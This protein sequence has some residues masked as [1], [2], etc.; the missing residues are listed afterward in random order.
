MNK[1]TLK[2]WITGCLILLSCSLFQNTLRASHIIGGE[3]SYKC[4]GGDNFELTL[5]VYRDCFYG[6]AGF[7]NPA[8]IAIFK[9]GQL[10][11]YKTLNIGPLSIQPIPADVG[12]PCLFVPDDVCVEWGRYRTTVELPDYG[13][14]YHLV[15]QRC[16]RNQTISNIESP[17][18]TGATYT[19]Y[20]TDKARD[21][22][23]SSPEFD[24][25]PPVFICIDRPIEFLHAATDAQGDS[26][27]YRLC[28][29][30]IGATFDTPNPSVP[31]PPPYDSVSWI[32][33][34][35]NISNLLGGDPAL[36]IDPQTGFITGLPQVQGQFVVGICVEEYRDGQLLSV[37]RRDFQ[38]NVGLCGEIVSDIVAPAADC[39]EDGED[40]T[41]QFY[42]ESTLSDDFI[43]FFDWTND[44]NAASFE[45]EPQYTYDQPGTYTVALIAEPNSQCVDTSYHEIIVQYNSLLVDFN[46]NTY[47]CT[48]T[49]VIVLTDLSADNV[50]SI[51]DWRWEINVNGNI[52]NLDTQNPIINLPNPSSG[53]I[54]LTVETENTCVNT[55]EKNF[56]TGG[57]NPD[58]LIEEQVD[59]CFGESIELNPNSD[60]AQ[61]FT[62]IWAPPINANTIN[63]TVSPAQTTTYAVSITAFNG[64]CQTQT[65]IT[66]DVTS[67]PELN[68][69]FSTGCDGVTVNFENES[70]NSPGYVWQFGD[71][72]NSSSTDINPTFEYPSV[73]NYSVT[74]STPNS[75]LCQESITEQIT[76]VEKVLEADINFQY[77][78]CS[79]NNVVIAFS[80]AST[81]SLNNTNEWAWTL[82]SGASSNAPGFTTSV[83]Q[84]QILDVEL[85]ITTDEGCVSTITKA[86]DID[87]IEFEAADSVLMCSDGSVELNPD[88]D[89]NYTYQW[90]PSGS[91]S[92]SN[93]SNPI[94]TPD[95]TTTYSVQITNTVTDVC[96]ITKE[97]MVYVPPRINLVGDDNVTTCEAEVEICA[98]TDVVVDFS[99]FDEQ[100]TF[101]SNSSCIPV[102][103]TGVKNYVVTARDQYNCEEQDVIVVVGG[104]VESELTE[105]QVLCTDEVLN[106]EL[107]NLDANDVLSLNWSPATAFIGDPTNNPTPQVNN[108]PGE[109]TIVVEAIN[110][111]GCTK[112]DSIDLAI[113]DSDINLDFDFEVQ[114]SGS[115]VQFMNGSTNAYNYIW[116]FGDSANP[117]AVSSEENPVYVYGEIGI[118]D[119]TLNVMFD[120][121]CVV[122]VTKQVEIVAPDFI[123]NFGYEF[124]TDC[125]TDS[126]TIIFY[127]ESTNFLNN[128]SSWEWNFSNGINFTGGVEFDIVE[129]T[130]FGNDNLTATLT[131]G[132]P[133]GCSGSTSQNLE[134]VL[135]ETPDPLG[136]G[137]TLCYGDTTKLNPIGNDI[138]TYN[139]SPNNGT[140]DDPT[141]TNP[142]AFPLETTNYQVTVTSVSADTCSVESDVLITIPEQ[143]FITAS[144]DVT[145][146]CG[147]AIQISASSNVNPT[148]FEW[149]EIDGTPLGT[150]SSLSVNPSE[151]MTFI[152][153]GTDEFGC[154]N[155]DTVLV[156][157]EIIDFGVDAPTE[158]CPNDTIQI[159]AG[160]FITDHDLDY[161]WTTLNGE[162]LSNPT[163][164]NIVVV[165]APSGQS[166]SYSVTVQNQF[167]CTA[168]QSVTINSYDFVPTVTTDILACPDIETEINPG[169]DLSCTYSWSPSI[170]VNQPNSPNPTVQISQD[171]LFTVT[172]TKSFGSD[173]CVDVQSTFVE[174][175]EII[176]IEETVDTLT[177]GEP[178]TVCATANIVDL[179]YIWYDESGTQLGLGSCFEDA[180]PL[181]EAIYI[182]EAT[183]EFECA[184]LDTVY[185]S[186]E[187]T[188]VQIDG[189]GFISTCP[190][191]SFQICI[192][193]L[194]VDDI[195]TYQ[196]SSD[197]NGVILSGDQTACPWVTTT[198]NQTAFFTV[199]AVNQFGCEETQTLEVLTYE[200]D[201][202]V[203][204]EVRVCSGIPTEL[205]PSFTPGLFYSWSPADC[206]DDANAPNPTITT[207]ENKTLMATVLGFNGADTCSA[208]LT[209]EV[210]VNPL[211]N[212]D[213]T[214]AQEV[215]CE[216]E[217][218]TFSANSDTVVDM[219]W[220]PN[221]DFSNPIL[222]DVLVTNSELTL[223]PTHT[224]TYYV[225]ATDDL[226]CRDSGTVVVQSYPIDVS[227]DD[228]FVFCKEDGT[229]E[230][231]VTNNDPAQNL[232]YTWHPDNVIVGDNSVNPIEVTF[233]ENTQVFV[234]V[235]NQFGCAITD[236]AMVNYFDLEIELVATAEP[237]TIIL[238]SG[239]FSQ[240]ESTIDDTYSY[241]WFPCETLDDCNISDPQ[242]MPDET[243][244]YVVTVSIAEGCVAERE[245]RVTVINPD[246]QEPFVFVPTAFSP[247]GD[248]ENDQLLVRGNNLEEMTF[249]VYNR[250]GQRVFETT[251][252]D[253]G[254]NGTFKNEFLSPGVYGYYLKARCFNGEDYFKKGNI[255]LVR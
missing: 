139:W 32:D 48:D 83:N 173:V 197:P 16:C 201:A 2:K 47:D 152:V 110:Q 69:D 104:P 43:W 13:G 218:I 40:L 164:P 182:V 14:G 134:I 124:D 133:N 42:N 3:I 93:S 38:Y 229:I 95:N 116:D 131:I 66:V 244:D 17:D 178:I 155:K 50:S 52:I 148:S 232:S 145:T 5:D 103:V 6:I 127:D 111:F 24:D 191:D 189:N 215:L 105:D 108:I 220:S 22:C 107:T 78:D 30:L 217:D 247:N 53:T 1:L 192:T 99:W 27:V 18:S 141:S 231:L 67:L 225:L 29:P 8:H 153:T 224:E 10:F 100:N 36:A 184:A 165:T 253:F 21:E 188:D 239:Q 26:L 252:K 209:V 208:T 64:G 205:N 23:N 56:Q 129:I 12:D 163:D 175:P 118:Y 211:I 132:T 121:D 198:P 35:Y 57:N 102:D 169:A 196:W 79:E 228:A 250:W 194:D 33:P 144:D 185:V 216:G 72:N 190:R 70:L 179:D 161:T 241:S 113:V 240:L 76:L 160:S 86:L 37:T 119:V 7:D 219:I 61:G 221:P 172:V 20:I 65:D 44:M 149:N 98:N 193:N 181:V 81:N 234:D 120:V 112:V 200:F 59:I 73:G 115:T 199:T 62:Y 137:I 91:L 125:S 254:W 92:N 87:F 204:D 34:P 206:V 236:S 176:D 130:V 45:T 88:G 123:P 238:G 135:P 156:T 15:Y 159:S 55:V 80:D 249:V 11:P 39:F 51:I 54:K 122:P 109:Q 58:D 143:I 223:N 4:I 68:F 41:I 75:A 28:N 186:N 177:C 19:I 170:M 183:D 147:S 60:P 150:G 97:V 255:T 171:G 126:V 237:D 90:S 167:D 74:L 136:G 248:G 46:I 84:E 146:T 71:G 202:V 25:F 82:G 94:A 235:E 207:T 243:T 128:T 212:L 138:F 210:I 230:M 213:A 63:P 180:N 162:I 77:L 245:V 157:N 203:L 174:V 158:A 31:A 140:I 168:Q 187:E 117:S 142:T 214:P 101:L 242:A 151:A 195:L 251:D 246:C 106:I 227:L 96:T 85:I 9:D 114:C 154:F 222:E 233:E 166:V 226:G 89:T 49:S